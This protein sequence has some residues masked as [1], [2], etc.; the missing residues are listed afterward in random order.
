M[1]KKLDVLDM[2]NMIYNRGVSFDGLDEA[3]S[4]VYRNFL[5][6]S[7]KQKNPYH[8]VNNGDIDVKIYKTA[9]SHKMIKESVHN[10]S[11]VEDAFPAIR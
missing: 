5:R 6:F 10:R 11:S 3:Q 7:I 8:R 4:P 1:H 2:N 9:R